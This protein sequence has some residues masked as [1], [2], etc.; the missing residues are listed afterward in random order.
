ML[1]AE[2]ALYYQQQGSSIY[3]EMARLY[4]EYGYYKEDLE[5][6]KMPG[7]EGEEQIELILKRLREDSPR[8]IS[9]QQVVIKKDYLVGKSYELETEQESE[10]DL[11]ESN[12]LQ[13]KLADDSLVTVRPSG[14]EPKIKFYFSVV[15]ETEKM[16]GEKLSRLKNDMMELV[17]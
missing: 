10:L 8:E 3:Q 2:M 13:F 11:P 14:T 7:K 9:N 5:A 6:L 17:R 12:V 15:G 1:I 16:A 4:E